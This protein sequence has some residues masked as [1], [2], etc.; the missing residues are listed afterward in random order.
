M[1]Q[2]KAVW[3]L[4]LKGNEETTCRT[5]EQDTHLQLRCSDL[6]VCST[7]EAWNC[8]IKHAVSYPV[9][10]CIHCIVLT[11]STADRWKDTT[12]KVWTQTGSGREPWGCHAT[13]MPLQLPTLQ[14]RRISRI[15]LDRRL[16]NPRWSTLTVCTEGF[17]CNFCHRQVVI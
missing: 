8:S 2:K 9:S 4:H 16:T 15:K 11:I 12:Y 17:Y 1:T 7:H 14:V 10:V 5:P 6:P 13:W 3:L